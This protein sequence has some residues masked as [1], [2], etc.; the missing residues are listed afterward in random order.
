MSMYTTGPQGIQM[1]TQMIRV[2]GA[3]IPVGTNIQA[4]KVEILKALDWAKENE[5]LD[6]QI[7]PL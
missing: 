2:A 7:R 5:Q 4:N 1:P 6:Y 3:Q